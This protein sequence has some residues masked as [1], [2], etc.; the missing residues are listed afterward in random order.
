MVS[1]RAGPAWFFEQGWP[2]ELLLI[3]IFFCQ[4]MA[5]RRSIWLF[6]PAG[7]LFGEGVLMSYYSL[8]GRWDDWTF[9]WPLQIFIIMAVIWYTVNRASPKAHAQELAV[10]LGRRYRR[11]S[12]IGIGVIS[13]FALVIS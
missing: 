6:I 13:F 2:V 9:L 4:L 5:N 1:G 12:I 8:S 7:L 11:L 10:S 3:A